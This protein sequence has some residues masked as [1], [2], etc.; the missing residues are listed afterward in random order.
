MMEVTVP[1]T[2]SPVADA[3]TRT[4]AQV[5]FDGQVVVE[6]RRIEAEDVI[7]LELTRLSGDPL[8]AWAPGAHIDVVLPNGLT[9]Q[10]SLCGNAA[11]RSSWRIGVLGDPDSR[12]GSRF[13][14]DEVGEGTR[15]H[16]RGPRNHFPL[17]SASRYVFIAGGIGITPLL[18]MITAVD[19][20]GADWTLHYGGRTRAGMAFLG[21]LEK[22]GDRVLTY[23]RDSVERPDL[24]VLLADPSESTLVYCCGPTGL[25]DAVEHQCQSW[26]AGTLH[27]ERFAAAADSR[28]DSNENI[29]VELRTTGV[30]LTVPPELSILEV[31]ENAG[32][33][34][35]K[36]CSEG[37]C[38]SCETA[39]L[40]GEVD[41]RDSVLSEEERAVM[42]TMM[43]CVSRA[44]CGRLVL[45]L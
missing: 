17:L 12:G 44:R 35:I 8:P 38:G 24:S 25:L 16:V 11:D 5:P 28:S 22:F 34:V 33:Q 21:E 19:A 29:E 40:E 37:I 36:S 27:V 26:P 13:I 41:H 3:F 31:V 45:D 23:P 15:L 6:R 4:G 43:I 20:A 7:A 39:V 30:T 10:Y 1:R 18:P 2:N 32:V 14:H 42:D 9:R